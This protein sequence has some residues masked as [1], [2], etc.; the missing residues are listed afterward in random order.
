MPTP[1]NYSRTKQAWVLLSHDR[2][3][4]IAASILVALGVIVSAYAILARGED[5]I[6]QPPSLCW[7][8]VSASP[9]SVEP[10]GRVT[11]SSTGFDCRYLAN[12]GAPTEYAIVLT[13]AA[14][15]EPLRFATFV[16]EKSGAFTQDVTIPA[17]APPGE[18]TV[19]I[20][21]HQQYRL[22]KSCKSCEPPDLSPV[23]T[24]LTGPPR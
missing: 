7:P 1:P 10:G 6:D 23:L 19:T 14:A 18:W 5:V 2:R 20:E 22:P 16:P 9:T 24:V 8:T 21:G 15:T 3:G 12:D 4:F 17:S 11:I 13:N